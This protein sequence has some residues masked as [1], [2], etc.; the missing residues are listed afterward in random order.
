MNQDLRPTREQDEFDITLVVPVADIDSLR[1]SLSAF[2]T[3]FITVRGWFA[4]KKVTIS[5]PMMDLRA[6]RPCIN[7]WREKTLCK[8]GMRGGSRSAAPE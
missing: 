4:R 8:T 5:G 6:A 7:L 1:K 2:P 3:L